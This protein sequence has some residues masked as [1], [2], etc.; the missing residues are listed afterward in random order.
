MRWPPLSGT[1]G[2]SH[3]FDD[4]RAPPPCSPAARPAVT[5]TNAV[6]DQRAARQYC[7]TKRASASLTRMK[8]AAIKKITVIS[9]SMRVVRLRIL[10]STRLLR[11]SGA[12]FAT[13]RSRSRASSEPRRRAILS[14][15]LGAGEPALRS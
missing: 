15:P 7:G 9:M 4:T 1:D 8:P 13:S 10:L 2:A 12:R 14:A 5:R 3:V 6:A 11:H